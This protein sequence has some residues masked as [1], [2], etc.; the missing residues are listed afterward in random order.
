MSLSA[1]AVQGEQLYDPYGYHRYA[2]GTLGTDK[3]YTGQF[4]DAATGL[5][6]DH[7][8]YYLRH[9]GVFLSPDHVQGNAQGMDPYTYVGGNPE[10]QTDP[11]GQVNCPAQGSCGGDSGGGG[12]PPPPP[13]PPTNPCE[14]SGGNPEYCPPTGGGSGNDPCA[15]WH[16]PM[17]PCGS[18]SGSGSSSSSGTH[19]PTCSSACLNNGS[20]WL[21]WL[22]KVAGFLGSGSLVDSF[23]DVM[24]W[25]TLIGTAFAEGA[26]AMIVDGVFHILRDIVYTLNAI[27]SVFGFLPSNVAGWLH[28]G[29]AILDWVSPLMDLGAFLLSFWSAPIKGLVGQIFNN[30]IVS[31]MK[32][33]GVNAIVTTVF[34][35]TFA[36]SVPW[37]FQGINE[38]AQGVSPETF[39]SA[40]SGSI[41]TCVENEESGILNWHSVVSQ[42][43]QEDTNGS[44]TKQ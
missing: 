25:I 1:S 18:G 42:K 39:C 20:R 6:Y 44:R 41:L 14:L 43:T 22:A 3:G 9:I 16:P 23:L 36:A 35:W 33:W 2:E 5:A 34:K 26:L 19:K 21:A 37:I 28:M 4:I 8:R 24:K 10:T 7:A 15:G 13:P 11:T 32:K 31:V 12:A 29:A 30:P 17:A 40:I 27:N 38:A